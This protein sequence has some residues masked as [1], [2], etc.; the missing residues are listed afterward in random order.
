MRGNQGGASHS[1]V[2]NNSRYERKQGM[3]GNKTREFPL[4]LKSITRGFTLILKSRRVERGLLNC[5]SRV[6]PI[7]G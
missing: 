2:E 7:Q 6:K 3:R 5:N 1:I 4:I